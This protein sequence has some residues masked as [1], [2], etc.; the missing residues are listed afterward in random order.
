MFAK[1]SLCGICVWGVFCVGDISATTYRRTSNTPAAVVTAMSMMHSGRP[2]AIA[3]LNKGQGPEFAMRMYSFPVLV[4]IYEAG[5]N[6]QRLSGINL[7]PRDEENIRTPANV[8][9]SIFSS[10]A[11]LVQYGDNGK[12]ALY[13][14]ACE[15]VR[16]YGAASDHTCVSCMAKLMDRFKGDGLK[17]L[18]DLTNDPNISFGSFFSSDP[19]TV[20]KADSELETGCSDLFRAICLSMSQDPDDLK[21]F[22]VAA[23]NDRRGDLRA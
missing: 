17:A 14:L 3:A 11:S 4:N 5:V 13:Q 21:L 6:A 10:P 16:M 1:K 19:A 12:A 22:L 18:R 20:E 8:N 7:G 23:E 2:D 9:T 15:F